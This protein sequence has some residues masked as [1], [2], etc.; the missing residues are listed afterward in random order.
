MIISTR[1]LGEGFYITTES[2]KEIFLQIVDI[3]TSGVE[4]MVKTDSTTETHFLKK[5]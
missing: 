2:G 4:V 5:T 1:K 3:T